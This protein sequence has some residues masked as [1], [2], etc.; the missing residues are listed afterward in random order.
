MDLSTIILILTL[1]F[2]FIISVWNCYASGFVMIFVFRVRIWMPC[3]RLA[4]G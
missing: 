4:L 2:N 3:I 1:A